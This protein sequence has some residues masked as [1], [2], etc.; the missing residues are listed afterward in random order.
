MLHTMCL[1]LLLKPALLSYSLDSLRTQVYFRSSLLSKDRKYVCIRRLLTRRLEMFSQSTVEPQDLST[2]LRLGV[3]F[4]QCL[5]STS[6]MK[7]FGLE[8]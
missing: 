6:V 7:H 2:E 3:S 8:I 1:L 4:R 5:H